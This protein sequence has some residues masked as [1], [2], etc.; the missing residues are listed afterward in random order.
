MKMK[1]IKMIECKE[2]AHIT[3]DTVAQRW[4]H[5]D[6]NEEKKH[7]TG[8]IQERKRKRKYKKCILGKE[9]HLQSNRS[10]Y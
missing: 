8:D 10:T 4:L 5:R 9:Y 3:A 1:A 2:N 6:L 7:T